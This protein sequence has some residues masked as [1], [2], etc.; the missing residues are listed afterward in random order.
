MWASIKA[1]TS[2]D[3]RRHLLSLLAA[4]LLHGAT[5][6][7]GTGHSVTP[8]S[9][10]ISPTEYWIETAPV[11]VPKARSV[12]ED[13]T[14]RRA[15]EMPSQNA[16][17][18]RSARPPSATRASSAL[19]SAITTLDAQQEASRV[20][21]G[22]EQTPRP[23]ASAG[24]ARGVGQGGTALGAQ[25]RSTTNA[26]GRSLIGLG[27][28]SG[29]PRARGPRLVAIPDACRGLFPSRAEHNAGTVTLALRV[30]SSG[31]PV[32]TRIVHEDPLGEGFARAAHS[33]VPR[34]RFE[35][36]ADALGRAIA[37]ASV[38]RLRFVRA[39]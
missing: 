17:K 18:V 22:A 11:A 7:A 32:A 31:V 39:W 30:G 1:S 14:P 10:E 20:T 36:A 15:G 2:V 8:R 27:T 19:P 4:A 23:S 12:G 26:P 9:P 33:C 38:V 21:P 13:D 29:A 5:V 6:L 25:S 3:G 28:G 16:I 35:P 34:L 24:S 37:S